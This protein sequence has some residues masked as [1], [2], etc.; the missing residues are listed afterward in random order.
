MMSGEIPDGRGRMA[1]GDEG[2]AGANRASA[3]GQRG[4]TATKRER[5]HP[6][7]FYDGDCGLCH[8][9]VRLL[10]R[11]DRGGRLRF[12]PLA[13]TTFDEQIGAARRA[14]LPDSLLLLTSD[15]RLLSR[16]RALRASLKHCGGPGGWISAAFGCLPRRL[17][18]RLYDAVAARRRHLFSRPRDACPV[19]RAAQRGRFLP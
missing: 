8:R 10:L 1:S 3:L 9:A 4:V 6:V 19:P 14:E 13:G 15:G 16:S 2:S 11:L 17:A 7:V 18:D 12:A 5:M